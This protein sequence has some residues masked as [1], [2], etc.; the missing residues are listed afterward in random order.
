MRCEEYRTET[1]QKVKRGEGANAPGPI[2]FLSSHDDAL[3]GI[4]RG[5]ICGL[6]DFA[7]DEIKDLG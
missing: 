2:R 3:A 7:E 4:L 1:C 5:W 6:F